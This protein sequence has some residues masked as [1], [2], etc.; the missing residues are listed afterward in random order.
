M[1]V[2]IKIGNVHRLHS[3]LQN[4]INQLI[5][6][7]EK[8]VLLLLTVHLGLQNFACTLD[9]CCCLWKIGSTEPALK[10]R[11]SERLA[12]AGA[13][14]AWIGAQH[15]FVPLGGRPDRQRGA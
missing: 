11:H 9:D 1:D 13:A 4:F 2:K 15:D 5:L 12:A 10:A 3:K 6:G 14:A 8:Y 7:K